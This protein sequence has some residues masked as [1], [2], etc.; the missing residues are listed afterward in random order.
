MNH[1]TI[2]V[3][4]NIVKTFHDPVTVEVLK[5]ISLE[6]KAGES[7]AIMGASGEG[8]STLL[9]IL[10]TLE[11]PTSGSVKLLQQ[12]IRNVNTFRNQHIGFVYQSFH[13]LEDYTI[14]ENV[15]MPARIGRLCTKIGSKAYKRAEELL[16]FVGLSHRKEFYAKLLSGGE[17]QRAAIAR[18]LC[19]QPEI[20][21]A[22]EPSGN[23]DHQSSNMI[24]DLLLSCV[25]NEGRTLITVTHDPKLAALCDRTYVIQ[26]GLLASP[27]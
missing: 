13:L 18:A 20:L 16:N 11:K 4:K 22:D 12:D 21:F 1:D 19:M 15:L 14:M 25:K 2:L 5:G 7:I 10:G 24:Y 3:A 6:V 27:D 17:K 9:R 23:L 26:G 8:K